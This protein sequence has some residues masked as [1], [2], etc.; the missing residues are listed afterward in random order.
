MIVIRHF[1]KVKSNFIFLVH[2][3]GAKESILTYLAVIA[4]KEKYR[5]IHIKKAV[6]FLEK[7]TI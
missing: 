3:L 6:A 7:V 5:M 2:Q 1:S 4:H